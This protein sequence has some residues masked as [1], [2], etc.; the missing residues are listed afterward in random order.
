MGK[1]SLMIFLMISLSVCVFRPARVKKII[2][3][4]RNLNARFLND[5]FPGPG[6]LEEAGLNP[7]S[8]KSFTLS[9]SGCVFRPARVKKTIKF[10]RNINARFLIVKLSAV[11]QH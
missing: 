4:V 11:R 8:N 9:L 7:L 6:C 5:K 10:A 1:S 2:K 3:F